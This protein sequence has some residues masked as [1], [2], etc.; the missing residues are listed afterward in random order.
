MAEDLLTIFIMFFILALSILPVVCI[1]I[2]ILR[3][4]KSSGVFFFLAGCAAV[5]AWSGPLV[6][7]HI[8]STICRVFYSFGMTVSF[9]DTSIVTIPLFLVCMWGCYRLF[10]FFT[11]RSIREYQ[12]HA[13][14]LIRRFQDLNLPSCETFL[15]DR[16]KCA[17]KKNPP[18]S[19]P[20]DIVRASEILVF[21]LALDVVASPKCRYATG[22]L[23]PEGEQLLHLCQRCLKHFLDK[24]Y[25]SAEEYTEHNDYLRHC[26]QDFE[27]FSFI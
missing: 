14:D 17:L 3:R 6:L 4:N 8:I 16:V 7:D 11:E 21:T 22:I 26:E 23:S 5:I 24:G 10:I 13:R 27:D 2:G 20:S 1:V 15:L 9:H 19:R 25:I 18:K 12:S